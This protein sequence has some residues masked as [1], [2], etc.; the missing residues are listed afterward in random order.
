MLL[1]HSNI[2]TTIIILEKYKPDIANA[3][4]LCFLFDMFVPVFVPT[5]KYHNLLFLLFNWNRVRKNIMS[6]MWLEMCEKANK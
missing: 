2:T 3:T 6:V 4:A 1:F 5:Y